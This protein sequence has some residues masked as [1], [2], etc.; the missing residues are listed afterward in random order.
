MRQERQARGRAGRQGDPGT[1][2]FYVSL[3]DDIIARNKGMRVEKYI[4]G[5]KHISQRKLKK[6][7]NKAQALAEEYAVMSR[8]RAVAYDDVLQ[9]QREVVYAERNR[10]LDGGSM[11]TSAIMKIAR[12]NIGRFVKSLKRVDIRAVNRYILDNLSYTLDEE[13]DLTSLKD[14]ASVK[15]YLLQKVMDGLEE[16]KKKLGG[17]ANMNEFVRLAVLNAIDN[18]WVEQVDYLLLTAVC[19]CCR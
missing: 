15:V 8:G 2:Q 3:E 19:S 7:I 11:S 9:R 17:K 6:M 10:L 4:E 13:S 5:E 12:E 14:S 18:A 16:Q 1:S